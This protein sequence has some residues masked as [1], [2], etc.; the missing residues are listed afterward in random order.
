MGVVDDAVAPLATAFVRT[1]TKHAGEVG[2]AAEIV[3]VLYPVGA[4]T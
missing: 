2:A 1:G 4:D 3:D